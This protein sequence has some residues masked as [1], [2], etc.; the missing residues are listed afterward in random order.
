MGF[1][2][3]MAILGNVF[4]SRISVLFPGW[5]LPWKAGGAPMIAACGGLNGFAFCQ[6]GTFV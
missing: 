6:L 4:E 5:I 1:S 3:N 2:T